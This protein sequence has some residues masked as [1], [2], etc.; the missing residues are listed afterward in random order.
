MPR[1]PCWVLAAIAFASVSACDNWTGAYG[2]RS[3]QN[4]VIVRFEARAASPQ[5]DRG[6][7]ELMALA[8]GVGTMAFDW[9]TSAG[10]LSVASQSVPVASDSLATSYSA[11]MPPR[12][13][14]T[15]D[16]TLTVKDTGGGAFQRT[17][18]F[19]VDERGARVLSPQPTGIPWPPGLMVL[20]LGESY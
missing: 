12:T 9:R 5:Q 1:L 16:V 14:G 17:A 19:Q 18:R 3:E 10:L 20:R 4:P 8:S 7:F 6:P 15:Y 13:P 2:P 11:Y